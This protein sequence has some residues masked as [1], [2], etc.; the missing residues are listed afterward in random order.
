IILSVTDNGHGIPKAYHKLV[1]DKFFRVPADN[2]HN[3]KGYGL[4]LSFAAL[5]ME[6]HG[7]SISVDNHPAGGCIFE[8][9]FRSLQDEG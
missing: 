8:L 3:V 6:Q 1:F 5:V 4:G 7:G 2:R 9:N